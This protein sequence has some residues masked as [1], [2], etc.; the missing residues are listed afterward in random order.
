MFDHEVVLL[1]EKVM[2]ALPQRRAE[3][4]LGRRCYLDFLL[5]SFLPKGMLSQS[6]SAVHDCT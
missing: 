3:H 2:H 6:L 1:K 5:L 4:G